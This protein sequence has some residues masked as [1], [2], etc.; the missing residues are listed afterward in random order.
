[1]RGVWL[2]NGIFRYRQ[3]LP[4]PIEGTGEVRLH[5]LAAGICGT[6]LE[7]A[8]GYADFAGIPGHEFV[9]R[10]DNED[11]EWAGARV[12]GNINVG[13]QACETCL[14]G[15]PQ[16]C[17][18]RTVAGIRNRSGAFAECLSLPRANLLRVPDSVTTETAVLTE[19]IA[20]AL[21]IREQVALPDR[22]LVIGAGR[23]GQLVAAVLS[24]DAVEIDILVRNPKRQILSA[25]GVRT[26]SSIGS[27]YPMVIECTGQPD[28]LRSAIAA[29][30]ARGTVVLK[31][32]HAEAWP[33][34]LNPLVTNELRLIGSRCGPM[35]QALG[36]LGENSLDGLSFERF[37]FAEIETAMQAARRPVPYKVLLTPGD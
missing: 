2:E 21:E 13:C 33:M 15:L 36:W 16:H 34:N 28:G 25:E 7:L 35:D 31:S 11:P 9:A 5:V 1:M 4:D 29:T 22:A 17:P 12:V 24:S 3:D 14:A 23:L 37:P 26:I 6:D 10:V 20:A 32:T 19:P 18:G 27:Q 8:K 30:Q